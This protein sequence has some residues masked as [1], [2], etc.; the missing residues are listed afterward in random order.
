MIGPS[1]SATSC[2]SSLLAPAS[3][4][5]TT[6]GRDHVVYLVIGNRQPLA[7]HF[8]FVVVTNHATLGRAGRSIL[9]YPPVG[10]LSLS[11]TSRSRLITA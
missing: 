11:T 8:D 6:I 3:G 1:L 5:S 9:R 10:G 2:C 7:V 4:V